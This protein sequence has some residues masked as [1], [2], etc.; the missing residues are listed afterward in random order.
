MSDF[1]IWRDPVNGNVSFRGTITE[2]DLQRL[3]LDRLDLMVID[4][5]AESAADHLQS[6]E[7]IFRR[8]GEKP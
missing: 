2:H 7:I 3:D 1:E 4:S 6:L 8:L 5:P